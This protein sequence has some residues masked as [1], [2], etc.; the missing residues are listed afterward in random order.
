MECLEAG[1]FRAD[2]PA[3]FNLIPS[4]LQQLIDHIDR[5][6]VFAIETEFGMHLSVVY[7]VYLSNPFSFVFT[8]LSNKFKVFIFH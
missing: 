8:F 4:A 2:I 5:D 3:S 1:V 7:S 6:L